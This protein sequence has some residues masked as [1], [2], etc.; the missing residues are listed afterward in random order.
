[1]YKFAGLS[2]FTGLTSDYGVFN[3]LQLS[4]YN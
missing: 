1:M 2:T 3:E 4:S